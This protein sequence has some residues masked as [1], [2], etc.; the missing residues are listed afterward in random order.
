MVGFSYIY[1]SSLVGG[2]MCS[3]LKSNNRVEKRR[4]YESQLATN[5]TYIFPVF[6]AG[7]CS[8]KLLLAQSAEV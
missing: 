7:V 6:A 5:N 8:G 4:K 1:I 2:R 3:I